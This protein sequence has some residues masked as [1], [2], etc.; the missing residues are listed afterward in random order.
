MADVYPTADDKRAGLSRRRFLGVA[1]GATAALA[2]AGCGDYG[3]RA[4]ITR[5]AATTKVKTIE[6]AAVTAP[7]FRTRPGLRPPSV[8]ISTQ[9]QDPGDDLFVL[10]DIHRGG[11]QQGPL[12]LDR[13]GRLKWFMPVSDNGTGELR[14]MNLRVQAYRGEPV[15]TFW[16]GS[17]GVPK[18]RGYYEIYDRHYR[19]LARVE[20]V[21]LVA[22]LH[23]FLI[24]PQDTA[25]LIAYGVSEGEI[26]SP[27]GAG[28]R[29]GRYMYCCAQEVDIATGELLMEWR[30][31][32]EVPF[33]ASRRLPAPEDPTVTW[34]YFHMNSIAIDPDDGNL[35]ISS[36]NMW[37]VYKVHR[38]TGK[39]MWRLGG[40]GSDFDLPARARFAFQHHVIPHPGGLYTIFDNEAGPP[41]VE[42]QSRALVLHVDEKARLAAMVREYH[43]PLPL[44]SD[45]MGSVQALPGG[46]VFVGWGAANYF[47]E[48]DRN[49]EVLLDA[50]LSRGVSY[51]AFQQQWEG[52]PARRPDVVVVRSGG[53]ARVYVSWNGATVHRRWRLWGGDRQDA[54]APFAL[55]NVEGF[56]TEIPLDDPP[57]WILLEALDAE[58]RVAGRS[59]PI[60]L[61][62]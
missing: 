55:A 30:S 52:A 53:R 61:V 14:V 35:I 2:A 13:A 47:T 21:N 19:S 54:L 39:T 18:A 41:N 44:L 9:P 38:H 50:R 22:D 8:L 6:A 57:R 48:W 36:R 43:H 37:Q 40:T 49:G 46:Q 5:A 58:D 28:T 24:T 1:G 12:I 45:A 17:V 60:R 59:K 33:S 4:S 26:P 11:G 29:W 3:S 25:L 27:D 62:A 10:T 51:R 7:P 16:I 34:D 23:E 15:L 31:D 42:R 32:H 56:E 20:A